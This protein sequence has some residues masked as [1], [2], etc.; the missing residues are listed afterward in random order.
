M[1]LDANREEA[2]DIVADAHLAFHLGNRR[3]RRIDV[4]QR[5]VTLAVLLHLERKVAK[6]PILGLADAA[7]LF[8][9]DIR[10]LLGERLDLLLRH[11][12]SRNKDMLV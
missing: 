8:L 6:T 7:A 12:L 5:V 11:V 1:F 4:H 10:V 3:V 2:D 9:E